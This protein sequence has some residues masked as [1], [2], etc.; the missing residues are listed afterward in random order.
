MAYSVVISEEMAIKY[1]AEE[2][3][4]GKII[5]LGGSDEYTVTGVVEDMPRNSHFTFNMLRS[6]E[7]LYVKNRQEME[8]WFNIQYYTYILLAENSDYIAFEQKLPGFI[9]T[10]MGAQLEAA[11]GTLDCFLQP[12]TSIYLHSNLDGEMG[13]NG[14]INYVYLFTAIAAFMLLIACVNFIN[15]ATARSTVR[16]REVGMRKALGAGR[17]RLI[18]QFL[19][20]SVVLSLVSL[21]LALIIIEVALPVF[22]SLTERE[23]SLNLQSPVMLVILIAFAVFVG[24]I[25]GSYPALILSAFRPVKVLKEGL[26]GGPARSRLRGVLVVV[27]FTISIALIIG[28]ITIYGQIQFMKNK[29]LGFDKEHVVIIPGMNRQVKQS[30]DTVKEELKSIPGV[31]SVAAASFMPGRGI[32]LSI[33]NPEGFPEDQPQTVSILDIDTDFI[34]TM[35]LKL[36]AG[37]NFSEEM[38]TDVTESILINEETARRFGWE[39]PLGKTIAGGIITDS[40]AV[41]LERKIIGVVKDYHHAS[42]HRK[43][44]PIMIGKNASEFRGMALR[45]APT[46]ISG[47]MAAIEDTWRQFDPDRP[48]NSYFLDESFDA[49]YRAEERLGKITLFFSLLAIFVGCLGLFGMSSYAVQQRTKEIGIRKV[50]GATVTGIVRMLSM[51]FLLL[52]GIANIVAWPIA[53]Y[54]MQKWLENFAYRIDLSLWH[55]LLA[56]LLALFITLLTVSL[57]SVKAAIANP[58]TSLRYE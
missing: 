16:A 1:F 33:V 19:G 36:A 43:I 26:S 25:A 46:D 10:Y 57:Q 6:M 52:V 18:G 35:G 5:T 55:F 38:P 45:I 9:E 41:R 37:R 58:V 4:V 22:N 40:G 47:T 23:L 34:G 42:L 56:G 3:P 27:Q 31:Q 48:F 44:E 32:R 39:E 20:E 51:R 53:Y 24:I 50:L 28:T 15:L 8:M 13:P 11:G 17:S 7:T 14:D 30:L 12:L 54:A 2:D 49:K 21:V 29:R